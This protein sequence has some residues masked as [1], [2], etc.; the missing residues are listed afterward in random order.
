M[1]MTGDGSEAESE[2][3]GVGTSMFSGHFPSHSIFFFKSEFLSIYFCSMSKNSCPFL[4]SDSL[5]K[6]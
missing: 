2:T 4:F 5:Y 1:S 3:G 6:T